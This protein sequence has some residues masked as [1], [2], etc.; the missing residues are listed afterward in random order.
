MQQESPPVNTSPDGRRTRWDAHRRRRRQDLVRAALDAFNQHGPE[1][2]MD[3][4]AAV[5]GVSKPVLYR[6]FADKAQL[7]LAVG[8]YVAQLVVEEVTP[9]VAQVREERSL[10]AA[11]VDAYLGAIESRPDLYRFLMHHSG[12]SGGHNLVAKASG[13]VAVEL[14]RVIGDR[15]RA[16]G[17]D[18]GPAEPWAY[19]LVGFVTAVGDWWL[20]RGRPMSR[21]ALTD[22]VATLMWQ[23]FD[24]VRA[25][26]DLPGGLRLAE[27]HD[28]R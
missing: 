5:A 15:L 24:G 10:I 13:K 22:Y 11:T 1:V 18:A 19:G 20:E 26:A 25:S 7:W 23:G 4:V 6:Y 28:D 9:A 21:A 27:V 14:S 17:L 8:E 2:D 16:L 3:Q 12:L